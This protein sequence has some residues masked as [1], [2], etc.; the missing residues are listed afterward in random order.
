MQAWPRRSCSVP[1]G[2]SDQ[3]GRTDSVQACIGLS[4]DRNNKDAPAADVCHAL[5]SLTKE[6]FLNR[7]KVSQSQAA[8]IVSL[9]DVFR[10]I[11]TVSPWLYH[12]GRRCGMQKS[13]PSHSS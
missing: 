9:H 11:A 4:D 3:L 8:L 10:Q 6:K 7:G 5:E 2:A 12:E 13:P 1:S